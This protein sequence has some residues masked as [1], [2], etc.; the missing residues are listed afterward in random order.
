MSKPTKHYL[1]PARKV[2]SMGNWDVIVA[3]GG[4][5]GCAAAWAAAKYGAR[6]LLVEKDGYLGGQTVAAMVCVV[7]STNGVDFQ[8]VWH[9]YIRAIRRRNGAGEFNRCDAHM[10]T[11]L[12]PEIVKFAWDDLLSE[13]GVDI[14]HHVHVGGTIVE[15]GVMKG[16][17]LDTRAGR[18][19]AFASRTIDGTGHGI[20]CHEAGVPWDQGDGVNKWAMA[21]TKTFRI[22]G[23]DW[24]DINFDSTTMDTIEA[25]LDAAIARGEFTS[26]PLIEKK[27]FLTY[28]RG[29][30]WDLGGDR[31]QVLSVLSRVLQVDPLDPWDFTRA[32]REGRAQAW[33]AAE[34]HRRF[35]PGCEKAYLLDTAPQIGVR[36]TR[37]VYGLSRLTDDDAW[38]LRKQPDSIARSSWDIDVW[39]ADSYSKPAVRREDADYKERHLK[40]RAGDYFDIP[41]GC[42]VAKGVDNL[43]M[44]GQCLS[45]S[46][47]AESSLRIQ[48][49]CMATGQA[50]GTAAA[51]SLEQKLTPRELDPTPLRAR[52]AR[53]RDS[54][55]PAYDFMS[56]LPRV[57]GW[58]GE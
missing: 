15:D 14:L 32:E 30:M 4:P 55:E 49:T 57:P 41:Y 3:G 8:G 44:A 40:I 6:T 39:P 48:Q 46:H 27:R 29:K 50:A 19:A 52:L 58:E 12:Y 9:D 17:L 22:A 21:L 43:M 38:H 26:P 16:L 23:M 56:E 53:D 7:L 18:R 51:M 37:R 2:P 10:T 13:A 1:E 24:K 35:V 54:V 31:N 20:V 11:T 28:V 5:A 25:K 33:E 47:I 42:I 45:A 34:A 36:S